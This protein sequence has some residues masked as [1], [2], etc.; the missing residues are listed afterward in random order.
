M[1]KKQSAHK[2]IKENVQLKPEAKK[3][4]QIMLIEI[5]KRN[6]EQFTE[7]ELASYII[8]DYA[9]KHFPTLVQYR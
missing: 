6:I 8:A 3:C 9:C 7:K 2:A 5:N 4:L 1:S